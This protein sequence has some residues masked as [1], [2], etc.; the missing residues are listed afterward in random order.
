M[1]HE[2]GCQ[3]KRHCPCP[4][5]IY[6]F[7]ITGVMT[8]G[9]SGENVNNSRSESSKSGIY[10]LFGGSSTIFITSWAYAFLEFLEVLAEVCPQNIMLI[11]GSRG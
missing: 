6:E 8:N 2:I 3:L 4:L 10:T 9:L 1:H 11:I 5:F 7:T